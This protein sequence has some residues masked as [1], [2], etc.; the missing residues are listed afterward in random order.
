[1]D[2]N[3]RHPEVSG[4]P[5][6][7]G[8]LVVAV[9]VD[10]QGSPTCDNFIFVPGIETLSSPATELNITGGIDGLF[11]PPSTGVPTVLIDAGKNSGGAPDSI[12]LSWED[13]TV[14]EDGAALGYPGQEL[15]VVRAG[16]DGY[17]YPYVD[18]TY[19]T[20]LIAPPDS[21]GNLRTIN[22]IQFCGRSSI[23]KLSEEFLVKELG[24]ALNPKLKFPVKAPSC[25]GQNDRPVSEGGLACCQD[26]E[27]CSAIDNPDFKSQYAIFKNINGAVTSVCGFPPLTATRKAELGG[28]SF[29]LSGA[30]SSVVTSASPRRITES[31][32]TTDGTSTTD[33][34]S[35]SGDDT[36]STWSVGCPPGETCR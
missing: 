1:M 36:V 21:D 30:T 28:S 12:I 29:E 4:L 32:T 16:N 10:M 25:T 22:E 2:D 14:P 15:V 33:T 35:S 6:T 3:G 9:K 19:D 13:Q 23:C 20:G 7:C 24:P 27:T 17:A 8:E 11:F 18:I 31:S 34:G 26:G 5:I